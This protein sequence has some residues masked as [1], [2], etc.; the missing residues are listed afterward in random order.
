MPSITKSPQ[1]GTQIKRG[2]DTETTQSPVK[3]FIRRKRAKTQ[4]TEQGT[5]TAQIQ[6]IEFVPSQ[7]QLDAAPINEESHPHSL[8]IETLPSQGSP[9]ISLD[10]DMIP[11]SIPDSPSL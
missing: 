9:S 8:I 6:S 7:I 4:V 1:P 10:V 11:T 5:H 2:R 3:A